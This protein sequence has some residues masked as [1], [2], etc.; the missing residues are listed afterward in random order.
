MDAVS[1]L[2]QLGGIASRSALLTLTTPRKLKTARLNGDAVRISKGRWAL[3][4]ADRGRVA[5][6]EAGGYLTHLSA[7]A[8]WGWSTLLP[9]E[10]PQIALPYGAPEPS[11]TTDPIEFFRFEP[12]FT[13]FNGWSLDRLDTFLVCARDLDFRNALAVADSALRA[14]D[15]SQDDLQRAAERWPTRRRNRVR[16]VAAYADGSATNAFESALRALA[17]EAGLQVVP[18][19]AIHVGG[20]VAHPDL[21]DPILGIALEADSWAHHAGKLDHDRD[22]ER[23]NALVAAGWLVLRFTWAQ[24]AFAPEY[25]VRTLAAVRSAARGGRHYGLIEEGVSPRGRT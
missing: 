11:V 16:R 23:Y 22:C 24:V 4:T 21:A 14:G 5:A 25:V 19:F 20:F 6:Q 18:Q 17:I 15:L 1:A 3:P 10:R 8:H 12:R 9:P 7:A 2:T 13:R